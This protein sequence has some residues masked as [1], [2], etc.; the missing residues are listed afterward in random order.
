MQTLEDASKIDENSDEE[1]LE[2][3]NDL[4]HTFLSQNANKSEIS[5]MSKEDATAFAKQR[6]KKNATSLL[7]MMDK[8]EKI[9]RNYDKS[10]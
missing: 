5:K 9:R 6:L 4:I 10:K 7:N 3:Q 2:R 1:T 8:I